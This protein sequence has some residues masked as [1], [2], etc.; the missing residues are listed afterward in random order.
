GAQRH[1]PAPREPALHA[2]RPRPSAPP[3]HP[4]GV[5]RPAFSPSR[6]PRRAP[7]GWHGT[8]PLTPRSP[9]RRTEDFCMRRPT[10]LVLLW[11]LAACA[12][13]NSLPEQ[14]VPDPGAAGSAA[15][16]ASRPVADPVPVATLSPEDV[17]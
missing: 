8:G 6:P 13:R 9:T 4:F 2:L 5:S 15:A 14:P 11:L 3:G 1:Q 16:Q 17:A 10:S 12:G 7:P